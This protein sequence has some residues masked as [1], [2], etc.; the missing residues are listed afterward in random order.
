[1]REIHPSKCMSLHAELCRAT[2]CK[3][4][5]KSARWDLRGMVVYTVVTL[6]LLRLRTLIDVGASIYTHRQHTA[7]GKA[8]R[9]NERRKC[10]NGRDGRPSVRRFDR[11]DLLLVYYTHCTAVDPHSIFTQYGHSSDLW[12]SVCPPLYTHVAASVYQLYIYIARWTTV[13][14]QSQSA[15]VREA[16]SLGQTSEIGKHRRNLRGLRGVPVPPFLDWGYSTPT[17]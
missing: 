15:A 4:L 6:L 5:L 10:M 14:T 8:V 17:F 16:V 9:E 12:R 2:V 7:A 1:M 13:Y 11:L 3:R